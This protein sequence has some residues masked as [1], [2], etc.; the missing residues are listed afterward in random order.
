MPSGESPTFSSLSA[1]S[2]TRSSNAD[3]LTLT[4]DSGV[5]TSDELELGQRLW[6]LAENV[7]VMGDEAHEVP[8]SLRVCAEAERYGDLDAAISSSSGFLDAE[9]SRGNEKERIMLIL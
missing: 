6:L 4:G 5:E 7:G 1:G 2:S 9:C 3:L 8:E